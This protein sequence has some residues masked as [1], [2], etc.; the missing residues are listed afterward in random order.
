MHTDTQRGEHPVKTQKHTG[1]T[2]VT[3]N[4]E[5][6]VA[7]SQAKECQ[8]WPAPTRSWR[9]QEGSPPSAFREHVA[10]LTSWFRTSSLQNPE[11]LSICV[12][13][14]CYGVPRELIQRS[15]MP[16]SK[17]HLSSSGTTV[18]PPRPCSYVSSIWMEF[19]FPHS[20]PSTSLAIHFI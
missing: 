6:G 18:S 2:H 14:L 11:R 17:P 13:C 3:I 9:R 7:L 8:R 5:I 15:S 16:G 10:L 4:A 12:L 20:L 1:R 19:P